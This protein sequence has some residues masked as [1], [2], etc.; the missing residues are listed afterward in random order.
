VESFGDPSSSEAIDETG[1]PISEVMANI[2]WQPICLCKFTMVAK[3]PNKHVAAE[4]AP[5]VLETDKEKRLFERGEG[6]GNKQ[7]VTKI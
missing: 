5:L 1:S 2:G 3:D 6:I 4:I 7:L